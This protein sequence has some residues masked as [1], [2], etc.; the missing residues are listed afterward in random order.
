[1]KRSPKYFA[2]GLRLG[3]VEPTLVQEWVN[4]QISLSEAVS[5]E[6]LDLAYIDSTRKK[7][8]YSLLTA[9]PDENDDY[10]A[11]RS[12]FSD[13]MKERLNDINFCAQ[14]ARELYLI[15]GAHNYECPDDFGFI[16]HFDD[17]FS[18]AFQG[19][20]GDPEM[21]QV[22]FIKHILSFKKSC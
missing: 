10:E 20:W 8:M 16:S 11:L 14:L 13:V 2:F 22:E 3:L 5:D 9:M 18:L 7:Q 12:L 6:L 1:M 15:F 17:A 21:V 19:V 4:E